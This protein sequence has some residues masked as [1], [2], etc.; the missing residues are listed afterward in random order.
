MIAPQHKVGTR[1]AQ[2]TGSRGSEVEALGAL[3][4]LP[5]QVGAFLARVAAFGVTDRR[6]QQHARH[7]DP[8]PR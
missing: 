1:A 8:D 3:G 5:Q 6:E 7:D 2:T 4:N